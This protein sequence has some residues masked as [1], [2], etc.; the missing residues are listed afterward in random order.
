MKAC[1]L[2]NSIVLLIACFLFVSTP[3]L[4]NELSIRAYQAS[5]KLYKN[6]MQIAKSSLS[7][8]QSGR[9]W[10]WRLSSKPGG[11]FKFFSNRKPYSETTFSLLDDQYRIHNI[12]LADGG[13]G[14]LYET[15]RFNWRSRQV[16]IQRK[17]KRRI[18]EL[19]EQVY[20]FLT[21]H[22]LIAQ[23][24]ERGTQQMVF[25]FYLKGEV[26]ES[27]LVLG[28]KTMLDIDDKTIEASVYYQ[29]IVGHKT[30][31][32]FFVGSNSRLLPLKIEN[33]NSKG[34]TSILILNRVVWL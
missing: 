11:I 30:S 6:G 33:I 21:I 24:V 9:F 29:T 22:L 2:V 19:P 20:D 14:K 8:E 23:M 28:E 5:Y 31:S 1:R 18:L 15:A 25:N 13:N 12:L 10:R 17:G 3:G 27:K 16:D 7:L 4:T 34:K 26:L 32:K